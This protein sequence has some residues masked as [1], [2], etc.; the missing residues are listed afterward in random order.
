MAA[1]SAASVSSSQLVESDAGDGD[2]Q[3]FYDGSGQFTGDLDGLARNLDVFIINDNA[4]GA[5]NDITDYGGFRLYLGATPVAANGTAVAGAAAA[6]GEVANLAIVANGTAQEAGNNRNGNA[7]GIGYTA[8]NFM[9]Y[10]A[11]G[12]LVDG[13]T[14]SYDVDDAGRVYTNAL[15]SY[16]GA[17][18]AK[19]A[20]QP[21]Q[22]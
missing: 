18:Q 10:D 15:G 6:A 12:M 4:T 20:D 13:L 3:A 9:V 5:E 17:T 21:M 22:H 8:N 7:S 1:A 14:I 11:D 2:L 16:V 19:P